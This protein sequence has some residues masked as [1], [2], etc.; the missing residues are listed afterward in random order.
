MSWLVLSL[1]NAFFESVSNAFNKRGALRIDVLSAAWAQRF[2]SLFIILP[3]VFITQSFQ[4]V[5]QTFWIALFATSILNTLTSLLFV[6]AIKNSPLSLTLPIVTMTPVFLLITSPIMLG[7][8]PKPLGVV[9]ILSTVIGSYILNLSKN[10]HGFFEPF[11]SLVKEE[12]PRLMLLVAFIWSITS[13]IDKIAVTN[14]NPILFAF[15]S[16]C[17]ILILLTIILFHKRISFNK[18]S[19]NSAILAPIGIASGLSTVFQ[20]IA[21]SMAIVPNVITVKR[22]SALFGIAWGKIF[23]KEKEIQERFIGTVV[24]ILGVVLIAIS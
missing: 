7:E 24:M 17:I 10:V 16:T 14:S 6:K 21:I 13:N 9:G 11:L 3:L 23:F 12:G 20:M 1:L 4:S 8:F 22:T 5:N 15:A 18:I 2:F 19:K